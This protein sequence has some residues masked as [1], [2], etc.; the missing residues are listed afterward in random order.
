MNLNIKVILSCLEYYR[1]DLM[2]V[3]SYRDGNIP[4]NMEFVFKLKSGGA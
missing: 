4:L 1:L 2:F 3:F